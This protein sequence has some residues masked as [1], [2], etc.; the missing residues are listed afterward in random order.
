MTRQGL[1]EKTHD[2]AA[3]TAK[4]TASHAA[5]SFALNVFRAFSMLRPVP[6]LMLSVCE[7]IVAAEESGSVL[8]CMET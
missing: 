1:R 5:E 8:R 6:T 4:S 7:R 3:N 2:L